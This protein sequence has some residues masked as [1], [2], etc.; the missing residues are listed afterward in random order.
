MKVKYRKIVEAT[1]QEL[2]N[3][4]YSREWW[5][6]YSFEDYKRRCEANG[7]KIVEESKS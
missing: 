1:E 7:T 6:L 4:W 3:Y 2:W 5:T